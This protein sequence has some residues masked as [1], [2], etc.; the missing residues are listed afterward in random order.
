MRFREYSPLMRIL[1]PPSASA[2]LRS[3]LT[4]SIVSAAIAIALLLNLEQDYR[5]ED[6]V[7]PVAFAGAL[8]IA[9][10]LYF[11]TF[12]Y[13]LAIIHRGIRRATNGR[14]E[15]IEAPRRIRF[16][17]GPLIDDYNVLIRNVS[18]LFREMEQSQLSIIGD[19]NRND[20]ILRS[21][22]G[23]LLFAEWRMR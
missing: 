15:P 1:A 3:K 20:A 11:L 10:I 7:L 19:R 18:S 13:G 5:L 22:S 6:F 8:I 9:L 16:L 2:M 23:S 21:L 12:P 4:L 17:F 14:L